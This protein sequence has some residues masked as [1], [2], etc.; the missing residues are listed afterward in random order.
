MQAAHATLATNNH[1]GRHQAPVCASIPSVQ[2]NTSSA[3][4]RLPGPPRH[5][6]T[7]ASVN[8]RP[9]SATLNHPAKSKLSKYACHHMPPKIPLTDAIEKIKVKLTPWIPASSSTKTPTTA[10]SVAW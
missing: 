2:P 3:S 8:H 1:Q 6:T 10:S 7:P 9:A 5:L 4:T